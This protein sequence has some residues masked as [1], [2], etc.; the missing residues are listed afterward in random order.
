MAI[1]SVFIGTTSESNSKAIEIQNE[2]NI[3]KNLKHHNIVTY[4][5]SERKYDHIQIFL[6]YVDMGSI[7][8]MLKNFGTFREEVVSA[9]SKQILSGLEY[10][11]YHG[12]AHRDIKGGNVL[13]NNSGEVKLTDFGSAKKLQGNMLQSMIGTVCWMPPEII[14]NQ[15]YGRFADI[16]S[17]GCTV[18]EML[19]GQPPFLGTS[20]IET[21]NQIK[22]F[23]DGSLNLYGLSG[24]A[25]D[26]INCCIKKV[27]H[28]RLNVKQLL[29][30]PFLST[31]CLS[32]LNTLENK[33]S[34]IEF[35]KKPRRV[36]SLKEDKIT[37]SKV[38]QSYFNKVDKIMNKLKVNKNRLMKKR[39]DDKTQFTAELF[40]T[41]DSRKI[42]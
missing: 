41:P 40:I 4:Y 16:W 2:I 35:A 1:K 23:K 27:A 34:L 15:E 30:H 18:Y 36:D 12:I 3:L 5:G 9:Y 17:F 31:N 32:R 11:H 8:S 24:N 19:K 7:S 42:N 20:H 14:N 29:R 22:N 25:K 33:K 13:V 26:F 39:S 38:N 21:C 28:D 10:L 37:E 6:E